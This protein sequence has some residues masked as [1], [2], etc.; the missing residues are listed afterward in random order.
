MAIEDDTDR[1]TFFAT[2]E[3]GETVVIA[4]GNVNGIFDNAYFSIATG[5]AD[6]ASIKPAFICLA[7]DVSAIVIGTSTLIRFGT[8]YRIV[9]QEPDGTGMTVLILER[10]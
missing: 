4:G 7:A 2:D 3:H 5:N 8:T 1:A 10:Q 9:N 6:V